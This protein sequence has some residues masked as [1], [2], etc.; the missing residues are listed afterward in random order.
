ML[1]SFDGRTDLARETDLL[2]HALN[3]VKPG[4]QIPVVVLRNG[5]KL[6]FTLTTGK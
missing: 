3:V 1:I 4:S 5:Q 2:H 6:N